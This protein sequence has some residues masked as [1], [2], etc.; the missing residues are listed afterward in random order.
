MA[1]WPSF[2]EDGF[3][4]NESASGQRM[5]YR[6]HIPP[7][8]LSNFVEWF[9]F[10]DGYQ[11]GYDRERLLPHGS[12]ELVID[13]RAHPKRLFDREDQSR[14]RS[15][16]NAWIS[17]AHSRYIVIEVA[18]D[19]SMMG[20]H[21]RPGGAYPFFRFPMT[22]L[23]DGVEEIETIWGQEAI[24]L[25]DQLLE[26]P[27]IQQKFRALEQFLL[28]RAR[29]PLSHSEAFAHSLAT[30]NSTPH[31]QTIRQV[32]QGLGISH[33]TLIE[34]FAARVGLTPKL[35]CRIRRFQTV[36]REIQDLQ[37]VDWVDLACSCGYY[38]QA[39]FVHDFQAF[40]GMNPSRYLM[41]RG[42]YLNY[43]EHREQR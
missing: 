18:K 13:L 28:R 38:D 31:Q 1:R 26:L 36:L 27:T 2:S 20:V 10:Y 39:H 29:R 17:G 40:S 42:E 14:S 15:F 24:L 12:M 3:R 22:D 32:A 4:R 34:T 7:P 5:I 35:F 33:K 43:M 37:A 8:P 41:E 23:Q 16:R 30:L 21:F 19:S 25:R 9:W 6:T 11:P